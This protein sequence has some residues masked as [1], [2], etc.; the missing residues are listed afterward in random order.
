MEA[1]AHAGVRTHTV[2][3]KHGKRLRFLILGNIPR[4]EMDMKDIHGISEKQW[5]E[6]V[7]RD[8]K[9]W[10]EIANR[11]KPHTIKKIADMLKR[12]ITKLAEL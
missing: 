1:V 8:K 11:D 9:H 2:T 10:R 4:K 12:L 3:A 7:N 6:I 5:K